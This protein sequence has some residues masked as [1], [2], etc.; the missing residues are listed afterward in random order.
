MPLIVWCFIAA[1]SLALLVY[2][3]LRGL[4]H[5]PKPSANGRL[6]IR[7]IQIG[8]EREEFFIPG[9]LTAIDRNENDEY[10]EYID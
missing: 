6:R 8:E 4:I 2:P 10:S 1:V 3:L 5:M 9:D 7:P